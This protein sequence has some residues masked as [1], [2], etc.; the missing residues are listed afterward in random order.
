MTS[1]A[2]SV[3][4]AESLSNRVHQMRNRWLELP[5]CVQSPS[6][7]SKETRELAADMEEIAETAFDS[8]EFGLFLH[9]ILER[10]HVPLS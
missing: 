10:W 5:T 4:S 2:A 9:I 7:L 1:V 3:T 8:D 6:S